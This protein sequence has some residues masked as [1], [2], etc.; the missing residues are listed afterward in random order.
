MSWPI[1]GLGSAALASRMSVPASALTSAFSV[2]RQTRGTASPAVELV[3]DARL[4]R[5]LAAGDTDPAARIRVVA[6]QV[7]GLVPGR[8]SRSSPARLLRLTGRAR[9][10]CPSCL[11]LFPAAVQ[12]RVNPGR[13]GVV[14]IAD[15]AHELSTDAVQPAQRGVCRVHGVTGAAA[16]AGVGLGAV[17]P[18]G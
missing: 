5:L 17:L 6:D 2:I 13:R 9:P 3:Q 10:G 12:Q 7:A 4:A 18:D 11:A 8:T 14:G 16:G 1:I 15:L